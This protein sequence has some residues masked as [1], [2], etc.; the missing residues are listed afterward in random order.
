MVPPCSPP[1][2]PKTPGKPWDPR[3]SLPSRGV[4]GPS[5]A[6]KNAQG[7][8][9][10]G[11]QGAQRLAGHP[12]TAHMGTETAQVGP[13]T[14]QVGP[15]TAQFGPKAAQ[16]G[17]KMAQ[18]DAKTAQVGPKTAQ[19]GAKLAPRSFEKTAKNAQRCAD[20]GFQAPR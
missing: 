17:P 20:F 7:C 15:K 11:L 12:K 1:S 18:V 9:N 19:V 13:E 5:W 8:A 14:A 4:P 2:A 6:A 16:V 3:G 10:S